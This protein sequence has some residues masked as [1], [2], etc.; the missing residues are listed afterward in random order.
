VNKEAL[1]HWGAVAPGPPQKTTTK[2]IKIK[3]KY[4]TLGKIGT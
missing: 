3:T 2:V 4:E 1:A